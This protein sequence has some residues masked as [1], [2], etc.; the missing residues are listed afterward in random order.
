MKLLILFNVLSL[1]VGI[2]YLLV[3]FDT[4]MFATTLFY[5]VMW[6]GSLMLLIWMRTYYGEI[7]PVDYDD[8][9]T[10]ANLGTL[11][12]TTFGII[13]AANIIPRILQ[14]LNLSVLY[15][16]QIK[17]ALAVSSGLSLLDVASEVLFTFCLV[18]NA[19]ETLK[20]AAVTALFKATG[21]ELVSFAVPTGVW[22]VLHG[23]I[24]YVGGTMVMFIVA[25]FACGIILFYALKRSRSLLLVTMAHGIYNT[26]VILMAVFLF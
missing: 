19:E 4:P 22:S 20:T 15:V 17:T 21:N 14:G 9:P 10:R 13:C 24:S 12:L 5:I 1:L 25:A 7:K 6:S 3:S 16:P 26:F 2:H 23:Y 8:D 18:A 11:I